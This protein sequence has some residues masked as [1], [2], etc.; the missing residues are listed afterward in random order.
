MS[1]TF[2]K[3]L[4]N[5]SNKEGEKMNTLS[6][7]IKY[8][9]DYEKWS[10]AEL[11]RQAGV[12]RSA[13]NS[14][15]NGIV[16]NI[17]SEVA[18]QL[19]NNSHFTSVWLSTGNGPMLKDKTRA[20]IAS[21]VPI[22]GSAKLG[23]SDNF[24]VDMQYPAGFGDGDIVFPTKD[25]DAYA[26]KCDGDSMMPRIRHGEFAIIEPNREVMPGDEVLVTDKSGQVMIKIYNR[27]V[28]GRVYF[29][30]VNAAHKPFS[31]PVEQIEFM[32][33]VAGI[34]KSAL[35]VET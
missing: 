8:V 32:Q 11:A 14:W 26:V 18:A 28:D 31:I 24:F 17:S 9:L 13:I 27:K 25:K 34:A 5:I 12:T 22:R 30:S 21:R 4:F 33:Y 3:K 23:E 7:R 2:Y 6:E 29:E 16:K 20:I 1:K 10:Q 35:K 19:E 15:L